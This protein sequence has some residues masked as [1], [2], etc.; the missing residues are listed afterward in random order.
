[1]AEEACHFFSEMISNSTGVGLYQWTLIT[2]FGCES[3]ERISNSNNYYF[4]EGLNPIYV[5]DP[6]RLED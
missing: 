3:I 1:M 6:S 4:N 2:R 5:Y